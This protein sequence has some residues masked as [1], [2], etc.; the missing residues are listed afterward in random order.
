VPDFDAVTQLAN[1]RFNQEF[2]PIDQVIPKGA[3]FAM[4]GMNL[5]FKPRVI[6]ALYFLLMGK[7][8]PFDRFGDIWCGV[9]LKKICDHLGLA[10]CSGSPRIE[11]QRASNVWTNL[12]K[13]VPGYEVN[14]ALW[15]EVDSLVLT[16]SS[17]RGCYK[18]LADK[19]PLAG[20]Y[21]DRLRTAMHVW[22]DL[23]PEDEGDLKTTLAGAEIEQS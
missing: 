15:R 2:E 3:F 4:C 9:F 6:P 19:L 7:E 10:I 21:W 22:A 23:F 5:A 11:H 17:F 1:C 16:R 8:W 13:E 18:E 14:E 12:R 20:E